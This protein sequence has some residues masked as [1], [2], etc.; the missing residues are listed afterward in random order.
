[1]KSLLIFIGGFVAGIFTTIIIL[2]LISIGV[3]SNSINTFDNK[4]LKIEYIEVKG[5]M[6]MLN[7]IRACLKIL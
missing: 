4:D 2:F 3:K 1:M 7:Y 5:K 6:V